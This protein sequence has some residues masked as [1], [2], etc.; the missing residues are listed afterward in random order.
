MRRAPAKRDRAIHL[1]CLKPVHGHT[2]PE[3][4]RRRHL[5]DAD[6]NRCRR[7]RRV[8]G[9]RA[10]LTHHFIFHAPVPVRSEGSDFG[11]RAGAAIFCPR[12]DMFAARGGVGFACLLGRH[13]RGYS[14][15]GRQWRHSSIP[16]D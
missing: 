3:K 13:V 12:H 16:F 1:V 6:R 11:T 10:G 5:S 7:Q 9:I 2:A 8:D 15:H 4:A 14:R